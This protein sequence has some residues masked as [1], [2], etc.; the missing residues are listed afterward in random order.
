MVLY[1][2]N[3][4]WLDLE[5]QKFRSNNDYLTDVKVATTKEIKTQLEGTL[6]HIFSFTIETWLQTK[7]TTNTIETDKKVHIVVLKKQHKL[8]RKTVW[9][10]LNAQPP[11]LRKTTRRAKKICFRHDN[12]PVTNFIQLQSFISMYLTP[13]ME[14][15]WYTIFNSILAIFIF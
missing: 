6:R 12:A 13:V 7:K 11:Y 2:L 10:S 9:I 15:S 4:I 3:I 1:C 14:H 5:H 8:P